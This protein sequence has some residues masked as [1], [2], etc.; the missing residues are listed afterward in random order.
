MRPL[1][2]PASP[3]VLPPP[4]PAPPLARCLSAGPAAAPHRPAGSPGAASSAGPRPVPPAAA[5]CA[6]RRH[7][8]RR[9]RRLPSSS[10]FAAAFA[11]VSS[12]GQSRCRRYLPLP[13]PG[14]TGRRLRTA[15]RGGGGGVPPLPG[16]GGRAARGARM[17]GGARE[18]AGSGLSVQL[19]AVGSVR[20]R[21]V[22]DAVEAQHV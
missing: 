15:R 11:S 9:H 6:P 3:Q 16:R 14:A 4:R 5:S 19:S 21:A 20:S 12:R 7:R 8:L 13:P 2:S 1:P 17:G 10:S 22:P 18:S